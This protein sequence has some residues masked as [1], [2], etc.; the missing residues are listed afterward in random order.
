MI[1][2]WTAATL[3]AY[4]LRHSMAFSRLPCGALVQVRHI[5]N[6]SVSALQRFV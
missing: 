1:M 6:D 3:T 5:I 4:G 2:K